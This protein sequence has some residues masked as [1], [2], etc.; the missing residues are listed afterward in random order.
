MYRKRGN[1]IILILLGFIYKHIF[2]QMEKHFLTIIINRCR[3]AEIIDEE[4]VD[5]FSGG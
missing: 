2:S 1:K 3:Y 4:I 5:L